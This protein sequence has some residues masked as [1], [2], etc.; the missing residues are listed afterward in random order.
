LYRN[1]TL[2]RSVVYGRCD[3]TSGYQP[4]GHSHGKFR[5]GGLVY[6]RHFHENLRLVQAEFALPVTDTDFF[7]LLY[8][9]YDE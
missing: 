4:N 8:N 2:E 9:Y 3:G 1:G 5:I 6:V 7:G